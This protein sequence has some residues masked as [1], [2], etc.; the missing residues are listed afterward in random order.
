MRFGFI[1]PSYIW[2]LFR[3]RLA[4]ASL[5]S[6][7][8]SITEGLEAPPVIIFVGKPEVETMDVLRRYQFP[9]FVTD[10][11]AEPSDAASIDAC[12]LYGLKRLHD[13]C[14]DVT[15]FG[16]L[17]LDWCYNR[18]WLYR[19]KELVDRHPVAKAWW[20]YRSAYEKFHKTL[21]TDDPSGDIL[22][23]SINAGGLFPRE[24]F[25][26]YPDYRACRIDSPRISS[27][28]FDETT[29]VLQFAFGSENFHLANGVGKDKSME[30][31]KH[32]LTFDLFDVW[33]RQGERWVTPRSYILNMGVHGQNQQPE[34]P[35]FGID[36]VGE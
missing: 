15:H 2:N 21:K 33:L 35:E 19:L 34:M 4:E 32:G 20:V 18:E 12:F 23:R 1:C 14:P 11:I 13:T 30:A 24:D 28:N 7:G 3:H 6:L 27:T 29:G 10:I 22:V 17:T 16:F 8:R 25:A 36:F 9:Q 31:L 5:A 26:L